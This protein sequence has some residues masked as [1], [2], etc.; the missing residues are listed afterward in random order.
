MG[1]PY[2]GDQ[3]WYGPYEKVTK[4]EGK[5]QTGLAIVGL[6]LIGGGIAIFV[7]ADVPD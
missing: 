2:Q 1:T 6:F 3:F 4:S 5:R 7:F